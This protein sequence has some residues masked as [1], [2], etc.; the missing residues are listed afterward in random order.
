MSATSKTKAI[1]SI[2]L[3]ALFLVALAVISFV[4][5]DRSVVG[6]AIAFAAILGLPCFLLSVADLGRA[7]KIEHGGNYRATVA[8][9]LL[10]TYRAVGGAI[11][12]AVA[13]YALFRTVRALVNHTSTTPIALQLVWALTASLLVS[14]GFFLIVRAFAK[15]SSS[16]Q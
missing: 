4:V 7:L 11:C 5:Q 13:G 9:R 16:E 6:V 1:R 3:S 14:I 2:I 10:S 15:E 8:T 12:V